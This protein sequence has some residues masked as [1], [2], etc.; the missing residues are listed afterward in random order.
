MTT[1][2][3]RQE[4]LSDKRTISTVTATAEPEHVRNCV[5]YNHHHQMPKKRQDVQN[6][7][8]L[9]PCPVQSDILP[10]YEWTAVGGRCNDCWSLRVRFSR[11]VCG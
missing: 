4:S 8:Q 10:V 7:D 5:F 1:I 11:Q 2:L 6:S 3:H 9:A